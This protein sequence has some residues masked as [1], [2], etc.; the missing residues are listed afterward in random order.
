[1]TLKR[2]AVL[3]MAHNNW[4]QLERLIKYFDHKEIDIFLH[5]DKKAKEFNPQFFNSLC[6]S[7][8][9]TILDR[10]KIYWGTQDQILC[11]L[12]LF[13]KAKLCGPYGYYHLLSGN[14]VPLVPF[15]VF[16]NFFKE[17]EN[18]YL[19]TDEDPKFEMRFQLYF[20]IFTK[21]TLLPEHLI[22]YLNKKS[23]S[24]QLK[25]GIN[26]LKNLKSNYPLLRQ[27]HNW[28]NLKQEAVDEIISHEKEIKKFSRFTLCGDEM[29]KQII[30]CNSRNNFPLS[31]YDIRAIDWSNGGSH[32]KTFTSNDIEQLKNYI[33]QGRLI[34]RKF[35][36]KTDNSII[37]WLYSELGN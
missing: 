20:N 21:F 18:N 1:M 32:P 15:E 34:A 13:K 27:G 8:N 30:L 10:R 23:N 29:Y 7:A 14:D 12:E 17:N 37:E 6:K 2:Q 28:C 11:E 4:N 36:E 22:Q 3:I 5:V 35:D 31:Y 9:F 24:L 25:L 26:R 19:T 33:A 16:Y